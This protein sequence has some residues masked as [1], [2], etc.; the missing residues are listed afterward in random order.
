MRSKLI[1]PRICIISFP[2]GGAG[3]VAL[4]DFITIFESLT[5]K[6]FVIAGIFPEYVCSNEKIYIKYNMP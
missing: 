6:I 4:S 5:N 1:S 2:L 3:Q